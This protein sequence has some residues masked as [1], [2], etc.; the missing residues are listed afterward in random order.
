MGTAA[1]FDFSVSSAHEVFFFV[2]PAI[3]PYLIQF[4]SAI[5]AEQHFGK[6]RHSTEAVYPSAPV[7]NAFYGIKDALLD[8]GLVGVLEHSPLRR[9]V[10]DFLLDFKGLFVSLEVYRV[11]KI[12]LFIEDI[13][14]GTRGP[15]I[16]VIRSSLRW[17]ARAP[18]ERVSAARRVPVQFARGHSPSCIGRKS[19][20]PPASGTPPS[21][22]CPAPVTLL[23]FLEAEGTSFL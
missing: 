16:D 20:A 8:N 11:A 12:L 21:G 15:S 2:W 6:H 1:S 14:Y 13:R 17:I 4:R 19:T 9:I 18:W 10:V 7:S 23:M 22:P 3:A 5:G